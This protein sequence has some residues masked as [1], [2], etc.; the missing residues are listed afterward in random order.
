MLYGSIEYLITTTCLCKKTFYHTIKMKTLRPRHW[1]TRSFQQSLT[2]PH[3]A[4]STFIAVGLQRTPCGGTHF[5]IAQIVRRGYAFSCTQQC[6]KNFGTLMCCTH[7]AT[8]LS[9]YVPFVMHHGYAQDVLSYRVERSKITVN[10]AKDPLSRFA[11]SIVKTE[12]IRRLRT[13]AL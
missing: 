6:T 12:D 13:C 11:Q 8:S 9:G 10:L 3:S 5:Q 1:K 7:A 2:S 4:E